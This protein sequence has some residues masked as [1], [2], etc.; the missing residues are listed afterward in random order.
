MKT[1]APYAVMGITGQVGGATAQALL[2]AG[3][4]VRGIVRDKGRAAKWESA[5]VELVLG[6]YSNAETLAE[7]F[8]GVD[9]A[10]VMLPADFAPSRGYPKARAESRALRDALKEGMP[11]KVVALSSIG[12]QHPTGLGL[13]TN[14]QILEETLASL[15]MPITFL[16]PAWFMENSVWDIAPAVQTG[17]ISSF[18]LPLDK[19]IPMVATPDI[20]RV[21]AESLQETSS[22]RRIVELEGPSRYSPNDLAEALSL[23]LGR[24]ISAAAV[25]RNEWDSLFQSQG[26]PDPAPRIE[27]LDGFNSDWISFEGSPATHITGRIDLQSVVQALVDQRKA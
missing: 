12:A 23:A 27:M 16:R 19:P 8:R 9:G 25:P 24:R 17:T 5:G 3:H 2:E 1:T 18:L 20:G 15:P 13:I 11:P 6:D 21:A 14:L 7:A 10:F 26:T 22:G 4:N